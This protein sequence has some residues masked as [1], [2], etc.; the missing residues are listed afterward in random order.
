M[1]VY[2][3][4]LTV[5]GLRTRSSLV[6][7]S[8]TVRR[9]SQTGRPESRL[10][11][12]LWRVWSGFLVNCLGQEIGNRAIVRVKEVNAII[13]WFSFHGIKKEHL[14]R[15]ETWMGAFQQINYGPVS[16]NDKSMPFNLWGMLFAPRSCTDIQPEGP[17]LRLSF[18]C[19]RSG[20]FGLFR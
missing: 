4:V 10:V 2:V 11:F 19:F 18:Q 9:N 16:P 6:C 13:W 17:V 5:P 20:L 7:N 15:L 14:K 12:R 3:S 8:N 1:K